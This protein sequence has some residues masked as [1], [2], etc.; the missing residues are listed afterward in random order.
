MMKTMLVAS[1]AVGLALLGSTAA[2]QAASDEAATSALEEV[3]VTAQRRGENLQNVPM[4]VTALDGDQLAKGGVISTQDLTVAVPGMMW[5]RS[6]NFSQ[7]AIRGVSNRNAT[8]GDEPNVATFL[9]GVYQPDQT[10]TLT[11]LANLERIEVL[12]GPQGTLFGRNATGG[13][14]NIITRRPSF[15]FDGSAAASYGRYNYYKLSAYVT[16]PI[17][18][19]RVAGSFAVLHYGDDGYIKNTINGKTQGQNDGTTYRAKLL[20]LPTENLTLQLNGLWSQ[21]AND[22]LTSGQLVGGNSAA[23]LQINNP[24]LNPL[25]YTAD[26]IIPTTPRRTSTPQ[27]PFSHNLQWLTDAHFEYDLGWATLSG[28]ASYGRNRSNALFFTDATFFGLSR[29]SY[30][31]VS[32]NQNQELVLTSAPG[33]RLTWLVGATGFQAQSSFEPLSS[34]TRNL[35]TGGYTFNLANYGQKTLAGAIFAE[36]T[37]AATETLF[38]TGGLRY[39]ADKKKA[40]NANLA[41]TTPSL[42]AKSWDKLTPRLVVRWQFAPSS[43]LYGSITQG[44][45]SGTFSA[46]TPLGARVPANP[47]TITSYEVG[48]KTDIGDNIRL[49]LAAFHYDYEDL[50]VSASIGPAATNVENATSAKI[51]GLDG[52]LVWAVNDKL[53]L[54]AGVSLLRPRVGT[55]TNASINVP[56]PIPL[57]GNVLAVLDVSGNDLIRAPRHT[58]SLGGTY[59]TPFMGGELEFVGSAFF[60]DKWYAELSNRVKQPSYEVVNASVTW[61]APDEKTYV[62]VFGQNLTSADYALGH[63][64]SASGDEFAYAK[65][66]WFGVTVGYNF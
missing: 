32:H 6:T 42:G 58:F 66:R 41:Q 4:A 25:G 8:A 43:N 19:D 51:D 12:K 44:Y 9:D 23:R 5:G 11:E 7:P 48:L 22:T 24:L 45:K 47:E 26:Q 64:V 37:F 60:S 18:G 1:T 17:L 3:V 40:Y 21:N 10:A 20:F 56:R 34:G 63:L 39:S 57:S 27:V 15:D 62:T 61:R 33:G 30:H 53:R 2:A 55:F 46:V 13:A 54:N 38:V 52:D 31:A 49:N 28:L 50:Q 65:P 35:V 14:V 59:T 36:A 29:T 16:G